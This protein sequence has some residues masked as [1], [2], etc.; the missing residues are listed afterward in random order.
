[1]ADTKE[2][3]IS[4]R[5]TKNEYALLKKHCQRINVKFSDYVRFSIMTA[6]ERKFVPQ[7]E[8][9]KFCHQLICYKEVSKNEKIKDLVEE[10]IQK[11]T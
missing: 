9:L 5:V 4:L 3:L 10:V 7:E 6:I 1:M 2:K 11:W 8:L